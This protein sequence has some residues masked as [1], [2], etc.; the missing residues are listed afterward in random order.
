MDD[1][2][3]KAAASATERTAYPLWTQDTIRY[4]DHDGQ[5]HVN[6]AVFATFFETGRVTHIRAQDAPLLDRNETFVLVRLEIDF[7]AELRWPGSVDIG[8][9]VLSVGRSSYR[10]GQALFTGERCAATA[11]AVIV[12]L[13]AT[14]RKPKPITPPIRAWLDGILARQA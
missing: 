8:L 3:S 4:A 13:D 9:R 12:L 14:T 7:L 1:A 11:V 6:N 10:L 2:S 5:G